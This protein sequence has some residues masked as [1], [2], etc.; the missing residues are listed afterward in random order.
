MLNILIVIGLLFRR[1][2]FFMTIESS[3]KVNSLIIR[4]IGHCPLEN[5]KP[6]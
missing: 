3:Q 4:K 1:R 5:V 6:S 2:P